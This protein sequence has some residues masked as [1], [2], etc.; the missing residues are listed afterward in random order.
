MPVRVLAGLLL[1]AVYAGA[2]S[3][4]ADD[5]KTWKGERVYCKKAAKDTAFGETV[6]GKRVSFELTE[7]YSITVREDRGDT[8]RIYDGRKEGWVKKDDFVL[9]RDAPDYFT[10][11]ILDNPDVGDAW[12]RRGV[13]WLDRGEFDKAIK[14][15]GEAIRLEP[16]QGAYFHARG[17]VWSKKQEYDKAI[18]DYDEAIRFSPNISVTF[19]TRGNAWSDKGEYDKAIRDYDEAIR[20][21]PKDPDPFVNRGLAWKSKREYDKAIRDYDEAIRLDPKYAG[22]FQNRGIAYWYKKE[23]GKAIRDYEEAIRL[24]PSNDAAMT[25]LAAILAT[26]PEDKHRDGKRAVELATKACELLKWNDAQGLETLAVAYAEVGDFPSAIKYQKRALQFPEYEKQYGDE[27]R[28][29]LKLF[30]AKKPVRQE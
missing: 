7:I 10:D 19:M 6:D 8:L 17:N 13:V 30:E 18:R 12:Y 15:F 2:G 29:R 25:N 20:L 3:S 26:C 16:R 1:A 22:A 9:S 27:G 14:D 28:M 24:D 23:N 11:R 4:R 5:P 21:D